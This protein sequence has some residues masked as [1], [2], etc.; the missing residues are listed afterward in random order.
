MQGKYDKRSSK[1]DLRPEHQCGDYLDALVRTA[2]EDYKPY[3]RNWAVMGV[4]NH[5]S[6]IKNRHETDL[7]E[8]LVERLRGMGAVNLHRGGYTGWVRYIIEYKNL[9]HTIN[10]AY[11]HGWGGG[12]EVTMNTIQL[13][14][15][16]LVALRNADI[17]VGGHTHWRWYA[18]RV[19][20]GLCRLG[21]PEQTLVHI[22]QVG[23][24]K[25]DYGDG[26]GGWH[27][28]TGKSPRPMGGYWLRL[29]WCNREPRIE[30]L[31]TE[32]PPVSMN[33]EPSE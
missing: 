14:N 32:C 13:S 26:S 15:R 5:E 16:Y 22:V 11:C 1:S 18:N 33:L 8:R 4:G 28:E 21:K 29:T 2:A 23:S 24:Y 30:V 12:G 7:T 10:L 31:P 25:N 17:V 6:S 27:V 20:A 19:Q 3:A 9:I